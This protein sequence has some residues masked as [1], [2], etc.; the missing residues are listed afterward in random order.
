MLE[1]ITTQDLLD[2]GF[3]LEPYITFDLWV[4]KDKLTKMSCVITC[5]KNIPIWDVAIY[6]GQKVVTGRGASIAAAM[7]VAT[8]LM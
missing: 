8:D 4:K 5:W 1:T 2:N 3:E 7:D 6:Y